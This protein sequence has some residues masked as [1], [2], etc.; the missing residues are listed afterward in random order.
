MCILSAALN[1][2]RQVFGITDGA[3]PNGMGWNE[4]FT[5]DVI[6]DKKH[7]QSCAGNVFCLRAHRFV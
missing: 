3:S 5:D 1:F 7:N 6:H 2:S 4:T